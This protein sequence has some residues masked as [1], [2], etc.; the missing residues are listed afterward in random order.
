MWIVFATFCEIRQ[1]LIFRL[2]EAFRKIGLGQNR[3]STLA[4][5]TVGIL[6]LGSRTRRC[7]A[8]DMAVVVSRMIGALKAILALPSRLNHEPAL[9][10]AGVAMDLPDAKATRERHAL[11]SSE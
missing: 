5:R 1:A 2:N 10:H 11:A 8:A 3:L 4:D 6:K 7:L 9:P